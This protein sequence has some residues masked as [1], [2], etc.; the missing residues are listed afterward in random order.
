MHIQMNGWMNKYVDV[1][2]M[3]PHVVNISTYNYKFI[4]LKS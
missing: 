1:L 2:C 4:L 3:N